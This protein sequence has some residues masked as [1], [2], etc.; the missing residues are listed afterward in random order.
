MNYLLVMLLLY[1]NSCIKLYLKYKLLQCLSL[2][3]IVVVIRTT[4]FNLK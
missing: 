2:W 4:N 3:I 1:L